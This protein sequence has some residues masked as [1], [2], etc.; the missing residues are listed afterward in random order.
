MV[1]RAVLALAL[2]ASAS[3]FSLPGSVAPS[4]ALRPGRAACAASRLARAPAPG[5]ALS[6]RL[7]VSMVVADERDEALTGGF[8]GQSDVGL[9]GL[10]VMGQNLALNI[11]S[12][13]FPISVHNRD[14]AKV[15]ATAVRANAEGE[16]PLNGYKDMGEFVKS[17]KAPRSVIMLVKAGAPVDAT[18]DNLLKHLEEGDAIIDGGNEWYEN[19][20]RR[21]KDCEARGIQYLGMGV[22][23]GEEGARNGPS[24]MPGGNK[25]VYDRMEGILKKVSAQVDSGPCVTYVGP[26]GAGNYVKMV[27]NGIE[28]GDMQLIT[29]AYDVL[30][31]VGGL[32]NDELADVFDEWNAGDLESFLV[33]ITAQIFKV[34]DSQGDG[35][36]VD[37]ILDKTGMKG[38]GKMTV[39][40]AAELSV[41]A[42]TIAS[43][44]D[45]RFLSAL[46]DE[47]VAAAPSLPF[48]APAL[49]VDKKQLVEDVRQALYASKICSYAQGMN[50]I[51]EA[52]KANNWPIKLGEMARIWKGGC[53]IRAQFLDRI[54]S[55]YDRDAE[56]PS[57]LVDGEFASELVS[58]Q[59][60]WRRVVGY[61]V[62]QGIAV[63][64]MSA[65]L[66]YFDT[67]R[68]ARLPANLIQAQ[69]DFFGAHTYERT[70]VDGAY[71]TEWNA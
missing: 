54:K 36:L 12:K 20:E 10:A 46:K 29:E 71:H 42:P 30:R 57:L 40:Q 13:G 11:A 32:T 50:L 62:Q 67:Y 48:E 56:L 64:S 39:Q 14:P 33:E 15:E 66:A 18:I 16:L 2:V 34:A 35:Y 27:H 70:D 43:S 7:G 63:P 49:K 44:L 21:Q 3:A 5:R 60:S 1:M 22:S 19:T 37:K 17:I 51:R 47:R 9:V 41:A 8:K 28:Y 23:G 59:A 68:R 65:S 69:R 53:I 58:R 31:T 61:A 55:A 24:L 25:A 45:A 26:G 6:S 4:H 52:A 38:T